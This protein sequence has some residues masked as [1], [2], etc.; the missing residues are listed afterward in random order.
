[1]VTEL[2]ES[3]AHVATDPKRV[4][5][6]GAGGNPCLLPGLHFCLT[7]L[8]LRPPRISPHHHML[9]GLRR[10]LVRYRSTRS[11]NRPAFM[12]MLQS[13]SSN[14]CGSEGKGLGGGT[15]NAYIHVLRMGLVGLA[16]L[17]TTSGAT[18]AGAQSVTS[19]ETVRSVR[20]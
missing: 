18:G 14:S 4:H 1:M 12:R 13:P 16:L 8:R 11:S 6:L 10:S 3:A 20:R 7:R 2:P 15:M 19:E 17:G 9:D 5:Y